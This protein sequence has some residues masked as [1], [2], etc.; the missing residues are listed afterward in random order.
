ML[1]RPE[2]ALEIIIHSKADANEGI[3]KIKDICKKKNIPVCI[4]D[5]QIKLISAKDNCYAAGIFKKYES[6]LDKK[7]DHVVLVNPENSGNLGTII[8]TMAG[9]GITDLAVIRPA[10]DIFEP[11]VIRASMGSIFKINCR[12]FDKFG[13]YTGAFNNRTLYPFLTDGKN[14]IAALIPEAPFSFIFG[15]ESSGLPKEFLHTGKSVFIP[16]SK[17]IDSFNLSIAVGIAL[18]AAFSKR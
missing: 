14:A 15:G 5:R 2:S 7:T 10:V 18:Y 16:Q 9:F 8:R 6:E 11:S 17:N 3:L 4:N 12:Y 13:S 1:N